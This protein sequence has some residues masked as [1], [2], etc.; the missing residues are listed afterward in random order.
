MG[1]EDFA[2]FAAAAPGCM[3][4]LGCAAPGDDHAAS[5]HSPEF[6][7]DESAMPTGTAL[8]R[9]LAFRLLS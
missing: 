4:R 5:L 6:R 3:I 2:F 8:F 9:A 7:L 1:A